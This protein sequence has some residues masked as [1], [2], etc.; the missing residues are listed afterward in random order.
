MEP[1][2]RQKIHGIVLAR[3]RRVEQ[4]NFGD[5][6][7]VGGGVYELRIH[8]GAG[9]RVYFGLDGNLVVLLNGGSKSTQDRDIRTAKGYWEDYNA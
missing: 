5:C 2:K 9:Y 1:L 6:D 7:S 3:L 4:S 8:Y